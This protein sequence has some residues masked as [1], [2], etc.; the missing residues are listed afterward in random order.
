M[1][2]RR[3]GR[4]RS[5]RVSA[6]M[7]SQRAACT[8]ARAT[9]SRCPG[10]VIA[11]S[12]A[13]I[14]LSVIGSR[15]GSGTAA[16]SRWAG[17]AKTLPCFLANRNSD[18]TDEIVV[19][20]G[21]PRSSSSPAR[22]SSAE[23]SLV[24]A[25][26]RL[27]DRGK[28]IRA[29]LDSRGGDVRLDVVGG[30][31]AGDGQDLRRPGQ[32]PGQHDLAGTDAVAGRRL[33]DG[34]VAVGVLDRR[35]GQEH[36][37]FLLAEIHDGLRGPVTGV[38]AILYRHDRGDP[39][40]L[41]ELC[42]GHVRDPDVPDF[43]GVLQFSERA[44]RLGDRH[45]RIWPVELVQGNL[46]QPQPPQAALAGLPEML[47]APVRLPAPR[48]GPPQPALGRD[49]EIVRVGMKGLGD[50]Q[51]A[52]LRSV[53]VG[54][55]DEVDVKLDRPAQGGLGP[56]PVRWVSPDARAGNAIP[57]KGPPQLRSPPQRRA[58]GG[59]LAGPGRALFRYRAALRSSRRSATC[60]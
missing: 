50:Q 21:C 25:L 37:L 27:G 59:R 4:S 54:S 29:E 7:A 60:H 44:D 6:W 17:L 8:A 5:A 10:R 32:H 26:R 9:I 47:G 11:C 23:M 42:L 24:A 35:P 31:G 2:M 14:S 49:D 20:S 18:R 45:L 33:A 16:L 15:M 57:P 22:M 1:V 43:P 52:D 3:F 55:V 19:W 13:R 39:L 48:T 12:T 53:G 46:I 41:V 56:L 40:R 28:L 38:V 30:S 34:V 58:G 36:E 51:L